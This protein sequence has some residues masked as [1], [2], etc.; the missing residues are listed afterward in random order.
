MIRNSDQTITDNARDYCLNTDSST[1][2]TTTKSTTVA[3]NYN[4]DVYSNYQVSANTITTAALM[5]HTVGTNS[6]Y[7]HHIGI[8]YT[9]N[10][11]RN[12]KTT[13]GH[14]YNLTVRDNIII[15]AREIREQVETIRKTVAGTQQQILAPSIWLGSGEINISQLMLDTLELVERLADLTASH[16]HPEH[17]D[18]NQRRRNTRR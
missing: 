16:S 9:L 17:L 1:E 6:N 15:R 8:D 5:D 11:E 10:V 7:V 13:V 2:R 12:Q 3:A 4:V 18:T 14:D